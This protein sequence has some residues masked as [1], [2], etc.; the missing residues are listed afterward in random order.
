MNRFPAPSGRT[1]AS[2]GVGVVRAALVVRLLDEW[3]SYLP[4][5]SIDDQVTDLGLSYA[6]S[7][8]L[9]ALL[10]VGGLLAGPVAALA[11]RGHR[12]LLAV[13]GALLIA[14]GLTTF[15]LGA[16]FVVLAVAATV[17][18]GA[19]D[20]M[21]RPLESALA[22]A[23]VE[24]LDRMLG[25]Q[26]VLTWAGDFVAPALLAIGAATAIG[27]RGV[28]AVTA[29]VF[30]G[31]AVVLTA[32]V[33]GPPGTDAHDSGSLVASARTL[34]RH[35]EL[36]LLTA[37][38]CILLPLDEAFLG[39]AVARQAAD[40][41]GA[42]AQLLAGGVVAGGLLGA[43]VVARRGLDRRLVTI[44]CA[45]LVCGAF[46]TALPTPFAGQVAGLAAVGLG[47]AVVWAKVH[48]RS[49]TLV[50]GRSATV[51]TMI[52]VLA[53]P[54]AVVPAVMGG[55]ADAA[56][57]TVALVATAALSVPL[58]AVVLGLGGG[59]VPPGELDELDA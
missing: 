56:S 6:Q 34:L 27:W 14:A 57:I 22:D 31:F 20:L 51:P 44:G 52:G 39:F 19:S 54:A 5:G 2:A 47:T 36:W 18:G 49:L 55:L 53:T 16:P 12:R 7:G 23:H 50:P 28:F 13:T 41:S 26:H 25:R 15:A 46:A 42:A 43:A 37:A 10:T 45:V 3:W 48:H 35:R 38:E 11:D 17:L 21:I 8:W 59:A 40:G 1:L 32:T 33:F 9:L 29:A 24:G 58:T 4:A 30:V